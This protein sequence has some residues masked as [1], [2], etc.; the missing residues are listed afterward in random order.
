VTN[1]EISNPRAVLILGCHR[2]GLMLAG[3][4]RSFLLI[5]NYGNTLVAPLA[6]SAQSF[7]RATTQRPE[8]SVAVLLALAAVIILVRCS[9]KSSLT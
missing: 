3:H 6:S 2:Y 1:S 8:C 7:P 4:G 9:P 5:R